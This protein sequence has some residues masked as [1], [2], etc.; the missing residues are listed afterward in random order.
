MS[1][2]VPKQ[3]MHVHST[4]SDGNNTIEENIEEAESLGLQQLTCVDHVRVDTDYLPDYVEAI[5]HLRP[6]T[7]IELI[8]GIEAK[9]LNTAGDLDL[10]P[11][12]PEG[13]D[14]I[15]AADHQVPL[16]DGPH[17]PREVKAAIE[18]GSMTAQNVI[19]AI[20]ESTANASEKYDHMVIAHMFSILPKIGLDESAVPEEALA[21]LA[22]TVGR[23]GNMIEISERWRCPTARSLR[24][25]VDAGVPILLSTDS[26]KREHI[27]RYEFGRAVWQE[28]H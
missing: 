13:I 4:F 19:A 16:A 2:P 20:I 18:D 12:L 22:E 7:G 6:T 15:Y 9:L 14:R 26:H 10:P 28:I 27:G 5:E 11:V 25:F 3:D 24:P 1:T 21:S 17:H 8:C 23:T